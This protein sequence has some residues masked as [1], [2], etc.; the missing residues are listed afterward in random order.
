MFDRLL[1]READPRAEASGNYVAAVGDDEQFAVAVALIARELGFPARVVVG[2]R[3]ASAEAGLPTCDDGVC[4]AQD[5]AVWAEVQSADGGWVAVDATPQH[6]QSPSLEVTQQRDP[7]NVTEVRPD[8]VTEVV[9]PDPLQE[10]SLTGDN[11]DRADGLDLAWLGP[12]L[13]VGGIGLLVL[14]ALTGPLLVVA[15]AK[16]SRRRSRRTQG[17]TAARIAGG[18]DE[19]VDAAIDAGRDAPATLTRT[20]LAASFESDAGEALAASADRAVFAGDA[21]TED[22]VQGFWH[23]VE[24][25]RR[26]FTNGRGVWKKIAATV[27]LRSFFRQLTPAAGRRSAQRTVERGKRRAAVLAQTTP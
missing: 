1:T 15:I 27:S 22:D 16:S 8:A 17:D 3:L 21:V 24:T 14:V 11:D 19:Y 2:A 9:P 20:E 7:Q 26:A 10:D 13:R 6:E 4:R 12:V 5:V 25:E 18:W 23:V